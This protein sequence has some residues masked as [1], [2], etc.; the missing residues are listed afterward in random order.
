MNK[1]GTLRSREN[2]VDIRRGVLAR[3]NQRLDAILAGLERA[4]AAIDGVSQAD[5]ARALSHREPRQL[6]RRPV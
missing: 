5:R 2:V 4:N 1:F 6:G 3:I